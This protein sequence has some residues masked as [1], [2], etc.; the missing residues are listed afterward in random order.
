MLVGSNSLSFSNVKDLIA[1]AKA[2]PDSLN[3]ATAG[4]G[5]GQQLTAVAFMKATDTK[6]V[7]VPYKGATAVYP[8]LIAGRVDL[9]FDSI[10]GA[11]PFVKSGK[12]RGF[13]ILA[14][15]RSND[16]PSVPTMDE[17]GV[18]G[19]NV[20]SWIG[21]FAPTGTPAS[22][23]EKLQN[24]VVESATEL[25][26]KFAAVGAEYMWVPPKKLVGFVRDETDKWTRIIKGAGIK[27]E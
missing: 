22:I 26:T 19:L 18:T 11:L 7:E 12:V 25:K 4:V 24:D 16:A 5:A 2:K 27:L 17:A 1:T 21:L 13:A 23:I 6:F 9:F 10:T 14:P 15:N 8:D 20:D 3:L